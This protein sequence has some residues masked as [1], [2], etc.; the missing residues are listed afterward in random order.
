MAKGDGKA[1]TATPTVSRIFLD[2]EELN[3]TVFMINSNNFFKL[4]DLMKAIDI[5][6][7]YDNQ[8]KVITLDTSSG[9]IDE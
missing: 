5:H 4:R 2:G 1:K 7:G 8:T 6:V 3:L 9:Y